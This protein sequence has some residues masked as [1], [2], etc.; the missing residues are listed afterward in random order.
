MPPGRPSFSTILTSSLVFEDSTSS[1]ILLQF[2]ALH[3]MSRPR[4][5]ELRYPVP[6][7]PQVYFNTGEL[8]LPARAGVT[9]VEAGW[10]L[11]VTQP[12]VA[13]SPPLDSPLPRYDPKTDAVLALHKAT[14]GRHEWALPA[15]RR[16]HPDPHMRARVFAAALLAGEVFLQIKGTMATLV[17]RLAAPEGIL[18]HLDWSMQSWSWWMR[19]GKQLRLTARGSAAWGTL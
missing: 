1:M 19:L 11:E 6:S 8:S 16:P 9:E 12:L 14:F 4:Q 2:S 5:Q 13:L 3:G 15:D 7:S 10:L 17:R 18:Q